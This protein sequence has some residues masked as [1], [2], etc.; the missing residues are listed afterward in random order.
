[1]P[2]ASRNIPYKFDQNRNIYIYVNLIPEQT[3][4]NFN[5]IDKNAQDNAV[6]FESIT[7]NYGNQITTTFDSIVYQNAKSKIFITNR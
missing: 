7:D 2:I 5:K 3:H 1:M 6:S 4:S